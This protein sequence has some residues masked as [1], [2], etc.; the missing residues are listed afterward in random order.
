MVA[1]VAGKSTVNATSSPS[2]QGRRGA[3]ATT[4]G[5]AELSVGSFGPY[6]GL[7]REDCGR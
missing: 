3:T 1:E 2:Q 6:E 7:S 4:V 5:S